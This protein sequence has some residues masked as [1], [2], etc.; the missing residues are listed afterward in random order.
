MIPSGDSARKAMPRRAKPTPADIAE[1]VAAISADLAV[2]APKALADYPIECYLRLFASLPARAPYHAVPP[3]ARAFAYAIELAGS[4]EALEAYNRLAMLRL[5][6]RGF[7]ATPARLT[8]EAEALRGAY[9]ERVLADIAAP[10]KGFFRHGNDMFAKDFAVCRG[11][12]LPCGAELVDPRGGVPRR[13]LLSGGA[14]QVL[15]TLRLLSRTG[16]FGPLWGLHFDRRLIGAFNEAGYTALYLRLADLLAANP[17]VRGVMSSSWWH[18]PALAQISP[19][20]SFIGRHPESSGAVVLRVGED[21]VATVD[22]TR[23]AARRASLYRQGAYRPC[24]YLL[25]W[26]RQDLLGW[27][28]DHRAGISSQRRA[29]LAS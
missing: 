7:P 13:V 19:E 8:P 16:G 29:P 26:S 18:D 17:G 14:R 11:L 20:L 15:T 28:R 6:E 23:F 12:L 3:Q 10:R 24:V 2:R 21:A 1:L 5:I 22:A 27:A 9:I 25:A 4:S